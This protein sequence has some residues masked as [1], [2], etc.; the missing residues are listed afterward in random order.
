MEI[1]QLSIQE[2]IGQMIIIGMI[3]KHVSHWTYMF[4]GMLLKL[5]T[6]ASVTT[7]TTTD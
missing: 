6:S 4:F 3:K 1:K 7:A 5:A 2:K